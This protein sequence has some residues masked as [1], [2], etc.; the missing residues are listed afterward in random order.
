MKLCPTISMDIIPRHEY[1]AN[2]DDVW[3]FCGKK[4]ERHVCD[5][6][7]VLKVGNDE[8]AYLRLQEVLRTLSYHG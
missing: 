1:K 4:G 5:D 3:G 7:F 8:E 6:S 2:V